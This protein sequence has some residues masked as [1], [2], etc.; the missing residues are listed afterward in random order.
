[1]CLHQPLSVRIL[2]D[3]SQPKTCRPMISIWTVQ[4]TQERVREALLL[5]D[6]RGMGRDWLENIQMP[7]SCDYVTIRSAE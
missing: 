2:S 6:G 5:A 3:T 4:S 1:M 7:Q